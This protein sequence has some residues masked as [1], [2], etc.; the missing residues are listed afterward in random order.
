MNLLAKF[1]EI[2]TKAG[3][4]IEPWDE[5]SQTFTPEVTEVWPIIKGEE[6]IGGVL[7][8]HNTIHIAVLPE[9]QGKWVTKDMI[10]AY[11]TWTHTVPIVAMI[12]LGDSHLE[13]F[14]TRFGFV[15]RAIDEKY[16]YYIKEPSCRQS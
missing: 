5:W 12:K 13:K 11:K 6:T 15:R 8:W 1:H 7:F 14:A 10:K 4:P 9:W 3:L 2:A 16:S